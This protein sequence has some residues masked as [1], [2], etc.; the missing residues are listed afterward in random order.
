MKKE[1]LISV[2][3]A[4][5]IVRKNNFLKDQETVEIKSCTGRILAEDI[6]ADRDFPPFDRVMMDGI[7]IAYQAYEKGIREFPIAALQPAGADKAVLEDE[8]NCIEVMTGAVLPENADTVIP[9]ESLEIKMGKAVIVT[10][11]QEK[12]KHVHKKGTDR[13]KGDLLVKKRAKITPAEVG[14]LATVGK[15]LV[16]VYKKP[17]IAIISTG[18]ELVDVDM[19]PEPHQIRKSNSLALCGALINEG[20]NADNFHF[21]DEKDEIFNKLKNILENYQ[22]VLLTGGVSK[23]KKDYI[24]DVLAELKVK[25]LFHRVAQRPGKPLYFGTTKKAVVFGFPGNPVSTFICFYKYFLSWYRSA[26]GFSSLPSY[27][28]LNEDVEVKP[29]L[30]YFLQVKLSTD[31]DGRLVAQPVPGKGSGDL[32]N[33]VEADGFIELPADKSSFTKG[34]VYPLICFRF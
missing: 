21:N 15:S 30:T 13:K 16:K 27:A 28:I 25:M 24:P 19:V 2:E 7:A 17:S 1:N 32:A 29:A 5:E 10:D 20:L 33:L 22:V 4:L 12:S 18:D 14:I 31:E 6:L 11:A 3:E 26:Y 34:S 9:Y 8:K 23:G